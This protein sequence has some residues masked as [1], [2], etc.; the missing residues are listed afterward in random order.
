MATMH[1]RMLVILPAEAYGVWL[2]PEFQDKA[3]GQSLLRPYPEDE[4]ETIPVSTLINSPKDDDPCCVN[5][6]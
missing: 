1:D 4:M 6:L 3:E 2:D 5:P